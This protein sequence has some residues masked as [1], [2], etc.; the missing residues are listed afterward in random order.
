MFRGFILLL[1]RDFKSASRIRCAKR[2]LN[3]AQA[4]PASYIRAKIAFPQ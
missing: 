1:L 2:T 4:L 3:P